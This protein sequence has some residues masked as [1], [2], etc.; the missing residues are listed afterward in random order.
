MNRLNPLKRFHLF[1]CGSILV[2]IGLTLP[3]KAQIL[4]TVP[5]PYNSIRQN[6]ISNMAALGDTLWVGPSLNRNIGNE[7]DWYL[8][9]DADSVINGRGRVFSFALAPDTI[10]AGLGYDARFQGESTQAGLG[11]YSSVDGGDTWLF[12]PIVED[13]PDDTL[14]TYG[15]QQLK[16]RPAEARE[17]TPPYSVAL[18]GK[19]VF[20]ARWYA[21]IRRSRDFGQT[22]E[23]IVLPPT[24]Q[25]ALNPEDDNNFVIT[26]NF[27]QTYYNNAS[28]RL[29]FLGF[30]VIIASD[31]SVWAGTA[32]G[33]NVSVN[34]LTAPADSIRW[35]HISFENHPNGLLGNW[36]I[37]IREQ[38][39]TGRIW[40]T[41]WNTGSFDNESSGLV[42]TDNQGQ[43]FHRFLQ[44]KRINDVGFQDGVIFAAGDQGL[45]ISRDDGQSWQL[46]NEIRSPNTFIRNTA[47]YLSVASTTD[48]IWIGTSDGIASS[49]DLGTS[50]QI[51]RVNMPLQGGNQFQ[52]DAPNV[53]AY[54][55]P[56]P[57]SPAQH[58]VVRIKFELKQ[59]G[60]V[61]IRLFDF[62]MHLIRTLDS[63]DFPA[64]T[65]EAAWDGRDGQGR[66]VANGTVFYRVETPSGNADGK[67]LILE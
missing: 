34:A 52:P 1:L 63:G 62:G 30:S 49:D 57:F 16:Y 67:I 22:W 36:V 45:Y 23:R 65:Y 47:Q 50:W 5:S 53:E 4:G 51:T 32:G 38:P 43:S 31:S 15:G 58:D 42:Y 54:A 41:N 27:N 35:K 26:P 25:N 11:Y 14:V 10:F 28:D 48:R 6:G 13:S 29:N 59:A 8:A 46:I 55:Y 7:A 12:T 21:G 24:Y 3:A 64:G 61:K 60:H 20:T 56:N 37:T 2:L 18:S 9:E 17:A 66:K 40:M 19:T 39:G 33:V 44:G